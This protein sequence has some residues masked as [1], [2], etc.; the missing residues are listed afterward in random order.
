MQRGTALAD[1][2]VRKLACIGAPEQEEEHALTS[3][4]TQVLSDSGVWRLGGA[5]SDV[6]CR[7]WC[8]QWSLDA[9]VCWDNGSGG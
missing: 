4:A 3:G 7:L 8:G 1:S 2:G 9:S 5:G 6:R